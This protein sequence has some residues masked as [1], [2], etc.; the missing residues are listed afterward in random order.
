MTLIIAGIKSCDSMKKA[1]A[2]LDALGKAYT[3][4]DFKKEAPSPEQVQHWL[5]VVGPTLVNRQGTTWRKL[6]DTEKAL[7]GQALIV[8][9]ASRPSLIKRP[10]LIDG[11]L[12]TV[13][14]NSPLLT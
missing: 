4:M 11:E 1:F 13:G 2:Q 9:I 12:I 14:L 7:D 8:L 5:A 3:F 6:S 10:L